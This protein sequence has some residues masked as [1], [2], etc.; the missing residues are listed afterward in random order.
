[1]MPP[2]SVSRM[3]SSVTPP[4]GTSTLH[5][6][7]RIQ[8]YASQVGLSVVVLQNNKPT[9]F[10]SKALNETECCYANIERRDA[11]CCLWSRGDSELTSMVDPL[12]LNQTTSPW[13]PSPRRTWQT[14]QPSCSACYCASR[15]MTTLS[16]TASV[17]KWPCLNTLSLLQSTS[18]PCHSTG[19]CHSPCSTIPRAEGSIST[20]LCEWSWD[21]HPHWHHHHR[22]AR[23]HKGSS[24]PLT[25]ILATLWDPHCWRWPCPLWWKPSLFLLWKGREHY[26]NYTSSIKESP[27]PSCL[28]MDAS[29]GPA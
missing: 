29:S 15:A 21:V 16:I 1:M 3:L 24:L 25:S 27:N 19:H 13:N 6:P 20:R 26:T 10:A 11:Y 17:R 12:P 14:H 23:W 2:S 18:W 4:S 9:A 22:F 5:L 8:V 28:H 7:W